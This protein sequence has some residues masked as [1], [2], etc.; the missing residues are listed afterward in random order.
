MQTNRASN[1]DELVR[2]CLYALQRMRLRDGE[3]PVIMLSR[4]QIAPVVGEALVRAE[5]IGRAAG[6]EQARAE[7]VSAKRRATSTWR[8]HLHE[9]RYTIA[10]VLMAS[11]GAAIFASAP[12]RLAASDAFIGF[13]LL[14]GSAAVSFHRWRRSFASQSDGQGR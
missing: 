14:G 2:D 1:V 5:A 13:A 10:V 9:F 4:Q 12:S 7:V 3:L 8:V 11:L 6:V